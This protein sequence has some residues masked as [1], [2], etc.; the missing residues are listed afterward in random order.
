MIVLRNVS[1]SFS[2]QQVLTG[3]D[4]EIGVGRT[5]ILGQSGSGKSLL[6]KLILGLEPLSSGDIFL[7][8]KAQNEFSDEDWI[9]FRD[10]T[11]VVFQASALFD[12]LTVFENIGIKLLEERKISPSEIREKAEVS[13]QQVGLPISIL[14]KYPASLSGGMKKRVAIARG[15]IHS[16]EILFYDEP[17]SGLDPVSAAQIDDLILTLSEQDAHT[18]VIITHDLL[19]VR[20]LATQVVMIAKG[21]IVFLGSTE[22]FF[23]QDQEEIQAFLKRK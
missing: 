20:K 15:I 9:S 17:T 13:L 11:G 3:I 21:G 16:P 2:D 8:G 23:Q 7:L 22:A 12:S 10:R 19:T 18:S 4:L 5:C 6:L 14:D 1:K